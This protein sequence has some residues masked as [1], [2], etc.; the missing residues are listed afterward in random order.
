MRQ[1]GKRGRCMFTTYSC[2]WKPVHCAKSWQLWCQGKSIRVY[3]YPTYYQKKANWIA[4]AF[5][6]LT[7]LSYIDTEHNLEFY[8][9]CA[10]RRK[11]RQAAKLD[12]RAINPVLAIQGAPGTGI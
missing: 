2:N 9:M 5:N 10:R 6:W 4:W 8:E 3:S 12:T 1:E 11:L 7:L